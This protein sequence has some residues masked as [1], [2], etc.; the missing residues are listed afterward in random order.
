MI[1][2]HEKFN[3]SQEISNLSYIIQIEKAE[4]VYN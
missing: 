4:C 3:L 1:R 2:N